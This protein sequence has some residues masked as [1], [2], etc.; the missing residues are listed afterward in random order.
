MNYFKKYHLNHLFLVSTAVFLFLSFPLISSAYVGESVVNAVL[1]IPTSFIGIVIGIIALI[2][3]ISAW[4]AGALLDWV[5]GPG[6]ITLSYTNPSNNEI[7]RI[8]LDIT[9]NF[10]NLGLVAALV[11]IALSIA[12]RLKEYATEKTLARLIFIALLVNFAPIVCGL[13][14]D[15]S[16]IVMNYFLVGI[17]EGVSGV[18]TGLDVSSISNDLFKLFIGDIA[19]KT[20]ILTKGIV[21]I[22]LNFNIAFIFLLLAVI[23]LLRYIAIWVLVILSPL[24]FVAWILPATKKFWDKWWEQ[25]IQWSIIGIPLAFFLYLA[26]A[27]FNEINSV[28]QGQMTLPGLET[29]TASLLDKVFPY[30]VTIALL[31]LGFIFG[32]ATSAMGASSVINFA[33]TKGTKAVKWTGGNIARRG[34]RPALEKI[35]TKEKVGK[36]S[37]VAEKIP[38]ARWFLPEAVRK[39]GQMTPA[40]KQ[41][42]E[43][44]KSYSSGTLAHRILKGADTQV[45]ATGNLMEVLE[46]GDAE[47]LFKEARQLKPF[48]ELAY[49]NYGEKIG[50]KPGQLTK[51]EKD[52][53]TKQLTDQ[54]ILEDDNFKK[55]II[56]PLEIAQG[57]GMLTSNVLRRDP[58]LAQLVAGKKWAGGYGSMTGKQAGKEA[59]AEATK[60]SR[61]PHVAHWEKEVAEDKN[62]IETYMEKGRGDWNA[63]KQV[64]KA[65]ET[66]LGSIDTIFSEY[67]NDELSKSENL[68]DK[69]TAIGAKDNKGPHL[70]KAWEKFHESFKK[71]HNDL[72]GYFKAL[73][74]PGFTG[75]GWRKGKYM[76]PMPTTGEQMKIKPPTKEKTAREYK[77]TGESGARKGGPR[78]TGGG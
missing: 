56:R 42:Q 16:N 71:K 46:R 61:S 68:E 11:F 78:D 40:I 22:V 74:Y 24:A 45:D 10:V 20:S 52:E 25:L 50:K 27:S 12:L 23:F 6:F 34:I 53:A 41:A 55:R 65:Q 30:F 66:A 14:V 35:K 49:K 51:D 64:K 28:F 73:E 62:V 67:I 2:S 57:G 17:K 58:R 76:P 54:Q 75:E 77:D 43:K 69:A 29:S 15:A 63:L 32:L 37:R 47:D 4:I 3:N 1:G 5:T 70:D 21:M 9:K 38:V 39:Y 44:T 33:K 31:D 48:K 59:V 8:G 19:T 26:M 7:I 36:I 72:D 60:E 18:L 13:I